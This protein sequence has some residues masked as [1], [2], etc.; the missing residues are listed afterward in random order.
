MTVRRLFAGDAF[1]DTTGNG[2]APDGKIIAGGGGFAG[3]LPAALSEALLAGLLCND[4]R[5]V[6]TGGL[7]H[8]E[9]NPTEGALI[10]AAAKAGLTQL[11]ANE[12][13]PRLDIV[14]FESERQFMATLHKTAESKRIIYLKGAV[15]KVW[16]PVLRAWRLMA[17]AQHWTGPTYLKR[18]TRWR[19]MDCACWPWRERKSI[20]TS[21]KLRIVCAV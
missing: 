6:K 9:G 20:K 12:E 13:M 19:P 14:P 10:T 15:E 5:L 8:I 2:Y 7:W 1:F 21:W 18:R 17:Q 4:A 3:E 16:K 11:K